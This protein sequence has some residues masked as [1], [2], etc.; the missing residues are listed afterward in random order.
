LQDGYFDYDKSDIR[1]DAQAALTQDAAA[2]K[3]V[4]A[5]S[6]ARS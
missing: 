1:A 6:P 2:L 5:T 4:I 3:T